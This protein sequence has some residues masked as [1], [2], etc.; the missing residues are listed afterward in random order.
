MHAQVPVMSG[1]GTVAG[2]AMMVAGM[3]LLGRLVLLDMTHLW[4]PTLF[5]RRAV[6]APLAVLLLAVG[7][8]LAAD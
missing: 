5:E 2:V 6:I 4:R 8:V 1:L 3:L 7:A